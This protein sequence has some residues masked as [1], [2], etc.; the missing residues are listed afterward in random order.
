[1]SKKGSAA[2]QTIVEI[3]F[4]V[5]ISFILLSGLVIA[6]IFSIKSARYSKYKSL[7]TRIAQGRIEAIK[8]DKQSAFFWST[9]S[10]AEFITCPEDEFATEEFPGNLGCQYA[11][12]DLFVNGDNKQATLQVQV[13]W[14]SDDLDNPPNPNLG[15]KNQVIIKTIIS[16]WGR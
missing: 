4:L 15:K 14:D 3:A 13:W 6:A 11:F 5:G 1:M 2:G 7:A 8:A 16:N 9:I 12:S 10:D